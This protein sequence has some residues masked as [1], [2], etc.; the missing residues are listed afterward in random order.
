MSLISKFLGDYHVNQDAQQMVVHCILKHCQSKR[1]DPNRFVA[2]ITN[3]DLIAELVHKE[4]K[5]MIRPLIDRS[6]VK[7]VIEQ[8]MQY[9]RQH[10]YDA[11]H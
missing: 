4:I 5:W 8:N 1:I 3:L 7:A 2:Q 6:E 11:S 9:I 10:I